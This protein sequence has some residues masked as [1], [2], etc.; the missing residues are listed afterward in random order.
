MNDTQCSQAG[1][2][3]MR[4]CTLACLLIG[5]VVGAGGAEQVFNIRIENGR[6]PENMRFVRV[7]E[8]DVV[9]LRWSTDQ[10]GELHIHGYEIERTLTPGTITEVTITA[11]ATGRFAM[12]LHGHAAPGRGQAHDEA[13]LGYFEVYPR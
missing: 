5:L 4:R 2:S 8:G 6:A 11:R 12:H 7:K 1:I 13:P 9:K 10:P 3:L